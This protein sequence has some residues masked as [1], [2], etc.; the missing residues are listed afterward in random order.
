M[1]SRITTAYIQVLRGK[2]VTGKARVTTAYVQVLRSIATGVPSIEVDVPGGVVE[3]TGGTLQLIIDEL[4]SMNGGGLTV[5]GGD[6][7]IPDHVEIEVPAGGAIFS[8]GSLKIWEGVVLSPEPA[9]ILVTGAEPLVFTETGMV[10]SQSVALVVAEVYPDARGSGLVGLVVAEPPPPDIEASQLSGLI[11]GEVVPDVCASEL[12]ALVLADAQPCVTTE[13]QIWVIK[14]T[15][16]TVYRYTSLDRRLF[17]R[18][19][20]YK[21]CGS[22][23]PSASQNGAVLGDTGSIS[24]TGII[25]D[26]GITEDELFG[27]MFDD[28][29]VTVDL[30]DWADTT[31]SP[32]R[33]TSGWVGKVSQGKVAHTMEVL[34]IGAR[35]EQAALVQLVSPSCR[36][37][38]GGRGCGVDVEA[39]KIAGTV[40]KAINRGDLLLNV[41][42]PAADNRIWTN[43][44]LRFISGPNAGQIREYKS[45]DFATG[46]V[47]LLSLAGLIPLAGDQVEVL[48]GCDL[49]RDG[50]CKNYNNVINFGGF[51][52]VPGTDSI[53]ETPDAKI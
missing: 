4:V 29:F 38:F 53:A 7:F 16:G 44:R 48:P 9:K 52:D 51:P 36:W 6:L 25:T 26:D 46:Q 10:A 1:A 50:G 5:T 8:G 24:L 40:R 33:L 14:R 30:V 13:C 20:W 21:S 11:V 41:T 45:I 17:W 31:K 22:M 27:G 34:T 39:M 42:T 32:R 19:H 23:D 47:I 37:A 15:D 28:A 3:A 35:L 43:G 2:S 12:V 18:G 49:N